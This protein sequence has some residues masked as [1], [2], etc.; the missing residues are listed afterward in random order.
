MNV[1]LT[2]TATGRHPQDR[3]RRPGRKSL[4]RRPLSVDRQRHAAAHSAGKPVRN[5]R[6][7]SCGRRAGARDAA[8]RRRRKD[9]HRARRA[10]HQ[11]RHGQSSGRAGQPER[12]ALR[13]QL[14]RRVLR[15]PDPGAGEGRAFA[16]PGPDDRA[17]PK[18]RRS[19]PTRPSSS[20]P[21]RLPDFK[22]E[23]RIS[24]GFLNNLA[25][26][27]DPKAFVYAFDGGAFPNV[28]L[29]QPRLNLGRRVEVRQSQQRRASDP[30]PRQRFPGD[31]ILRS[32]D[33]TAHRRG[34]VSASTMPT[35]RHRPCRSTRASSSPAFL[36][37][38]PGSTTTPVFT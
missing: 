12:A 29:I 14:C 8:A 4:S 17:S 30:R 16:R 23:I 32:D 13:R 15:L 22:R 36:R 9:D 19:A 20:F 2:E 38:A 21:T 26:R 1:Q 6:D 34:Q 37:S 24:G 35:R 31:R 11:Q 5:R 33:G 10:L 3:H 7:N 18:D 28:P 25:S 27:E